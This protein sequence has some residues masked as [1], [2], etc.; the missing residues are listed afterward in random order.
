MIDNKNNGLNI[1]SDVDSF[2]D[3]HP[4]LSKCKKLSCYLKIRLYIL[5]LVKACM[6]KFMYDLLP[7]KDFRISQMFKWYR[8]I[9]RPSSVKIKLRSEWY[10][11]R[12]RGEFKF[13]VA[14]SFYGC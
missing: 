2:K 5:I 12:I 7:S 9:D 1:F 8:G 10:S 14:I 4:V 11:F 13:F 3:K 6:L